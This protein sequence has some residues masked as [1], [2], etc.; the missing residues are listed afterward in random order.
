MAGPVVWTWSL[1]LSSSSTSSPTWR[2]ATTSGQVADLT[3]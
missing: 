2:P 3:G 1:S